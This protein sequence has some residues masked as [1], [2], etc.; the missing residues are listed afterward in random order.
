MREPFDESFTSLV[1]TM[2]YISVY[3]SMSLLTLHIGVYVRGS[4]F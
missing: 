2:I 3:V 1:H 4:V